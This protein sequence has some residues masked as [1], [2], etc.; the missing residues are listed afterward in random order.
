MEIELKP[1]AKLDLP[2]LRGISF[3]GHQEAATI[4]KGPLQ[5]LIPELEAQ[6][7]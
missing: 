2:E 7:A 3:Q 1:E 4:F 5:G 6:I